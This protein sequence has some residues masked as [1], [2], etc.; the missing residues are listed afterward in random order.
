[1][2]FKKNSKPKK[3]KLEEKISEGPT[4]VSEEIEEAQE[5][6]R[7]E[8]NEVLGKSKEPEKGGEADKVYD[9]QAYAPLNEK[10]SDEQY[11]EQ[12]NAVK[13]QGGMVSQLKQK[14]MDWYLM[15]PK[16]GHPGREE[17]EKLL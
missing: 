12:K 14:I 6:V 5:E 16:K 2:L 4:N 15:L 8:A 1:M 3:E 11:S 7:A 10:R 9:T 13:Y 17:K